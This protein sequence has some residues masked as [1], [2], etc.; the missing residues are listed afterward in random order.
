MDGNGRWAKKRSLPRVAGHKKGADAL[1]EIMTGCRDAGVTHLTIY[2]FSSEN[3]KRPA[4]EV[5][6]LMELLRH[7]L[8]KEIATLHKNGIR[9]RIIGD[10]SKLAPD[11]IKQI[12]DAEALTEKNTA[13]YFQVALSYGSRQEITNSVKTLVA[14]IHSGK[15]KPEDITEESIN[16]TL[17]TAGLPDPDLLIR[18]GGEH[19]ISNFLL[20]QCAYT[21]L[22]FTPTLWPDFS[23]TNLQ[24]ALTEFA[25]RERRYGNTA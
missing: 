16:S 4:V 11:I 6:D 7:F 10:R 18:T 14:D 5:K 19:R 23:V 3:W 17:Y 12:Q 9:L 25:T 21:E 15:I 13:F 1:R 8:G 24:E 20:W 22:Y 2:A